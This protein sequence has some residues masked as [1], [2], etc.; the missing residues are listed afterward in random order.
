MARN[1]NLENSPEKFLKM[2]RRASASQ[3]WTVAFDCYLQAAEGGVVQAMTAVGNMYLDGCGTE[4]NDEK[5]LHWLQKA[6]ALDEPNALK[7]LARYHCDGI[8]SR[9]DIDHIIDLYKKAIALGDVAAMNEL[10]DFYFE[11]ED[12]E[13]AGKYYEDAAKAG[14]LDGMANLG[15]MLTYVEGFHLNEAYYWLKR[16]LDGGNEYALKLIGELFE[17][18]GKFY[19]AERWYRRAVKENVESAEKNL[20]AIRNLLRKMKGRSCKIVWEPAPHE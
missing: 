16:S 6:A 19:K 17:E 15:I 13:A 20:R 11:L 1:V 8:E 2:A 14:D 18:Y 12:F 3:N 5:A 10:G 9:E 7:S 4:A